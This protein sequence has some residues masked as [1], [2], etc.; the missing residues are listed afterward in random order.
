MDR[1]YEKGF[2]SNPKGNKEIWILP[3]FG[4]RVPFP[5]EQSEF[6]EFDAAF[7]P[8]GGWLAYV[9]EESG[10]REVYV[11]S[12]PA[13]GEKLQIST[14]GGVTPK[15]RADGK[16]LFYQALDNQLMAVKLEPGARLKAIAPTALF[17]MSPTSINKIYDVSAD[18]QSILVNAV[19]REEKPS[20]IT[21]VL[22]WTAG[23]KEN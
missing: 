13:R 3:L 22:N 14:A 8:D 9:S 5:F 11:Q 10:G 16:E 7:S 20:P 17:K 1:L 2:I 23:L 12:F 18:G 6:S 4:G 19:A 21:V 15:W